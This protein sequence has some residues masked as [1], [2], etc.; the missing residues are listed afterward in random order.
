MTLDV[1][2]VST[3]ICELKL[4]M[5]GHL[6]YKTTFFIHIEFAKQILQSTTL[7]LGQFTICIDLLFTYDLLFDNW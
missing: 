4:L 2:Q 7:C 1:D 6:M 3:I 5:I